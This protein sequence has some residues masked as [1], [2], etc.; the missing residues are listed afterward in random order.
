MQTI[1]V[2]AS[3]KYDIIIGR[4][5]L[6]SCGS[7]IKNVTNA[8]AAA[9]ITDDNVDKF[10]GDKVVSS[11][12][13]AGISVCKFV[14]PHGEASKCVSVLQDIYGFLCENHITRSDCLIALGGGVTGDMTGFAAA[15]YLRGVDYIQIPT[16]LLAQV[17][18]SVGGKTAVDLP[19]GKNLVGSFKQ[20]ELV[21]CDIDTLSTLPEDFITDGMGEVVKYGMIRSK[22]LFDIL[23]ANDIRSIKNIAEDIIFR[24]VSIKRDV[25]EADEFDKG[26]RM[27]LNFGHTLGHSIEQHYNYTGISHGCAVAEGMAAITA[28]AEAKGQCE[29]GL[30]EKLCGCLEKYGLPTKPDV[31]LSVLADACLNDK[32]REGGNIN[33]I[34]C[35]SCGSSKAVCMTVDEFIDFI[36][37]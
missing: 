14:F 19:W 34:I 1:T 10:Y 11:L 8:S 23:D 2:N 4:E 21:L 36:C 28:V 32:K 9:V 15:T 26:E 22:E 16:S 3:K 37:N 25:V 6:E 29:K 20:P 5:L 27:I 13:S 12:K 24:C 18:S 7:Y 33:I 17:D 35:G 31:P 30:T